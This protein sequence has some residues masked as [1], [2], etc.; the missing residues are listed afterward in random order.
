MSTKKW[1]AVLEILFTST[2]VNQHIGKE[3]TLSTSNTDIYGFTF[4]I[5]LFTPVFSGLKI[6]WQTKRLKVLQ[7]RYACSSTITCSRI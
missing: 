7:L 3:E 4:F 2:R 1:N 5:N 6:F